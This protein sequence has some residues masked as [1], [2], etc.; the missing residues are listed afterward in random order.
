MQVLFTLPQ[1][2][3]QYVKAANDIYESINFDNTGKL[4]K[5]QNNP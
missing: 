4:W 5:L 1:F 3:E 2:Q